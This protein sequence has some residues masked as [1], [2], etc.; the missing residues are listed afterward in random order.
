MFA[1]L[2]YILFCCVDVR[3]WNGD[4]G[5]VVHGGAHVPHDLALHGEAHLDELVVHV[6]EPRGGVGPHGPGVH[7]G[8]GHVVLPVGIHHHVEVLVGGLVRLLIQCLGLL[9]S[10]VLVWSWSGLVVLLGCCVVSCDCVVVVF[11][12]VLLC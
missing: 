5:E 3:S 9:W 1:L 12:F 8:H 2:V 4:G 7:E 11:C 6:L 10:S